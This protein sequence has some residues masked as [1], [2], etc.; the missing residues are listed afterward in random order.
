[1]SKAAILGMDVGG[2]S[3]RSAL[4]HIEDASLSPVPF[5]EHREPTARGVEAHGQQM[6]RIIILAAEQANPLI[7]I[8]VGSPGRFDAEGKIKPG[9]NP[10]V[11]M[12]VHEFDGVNLADLYRTNLPEAFRNIPLNVRNDADAMLAGMIHAIQQEK[13]SSL[14]ANEIEGRTLALFGLGTGLGHS[15]VKLDNTGGYQF[16]TDGH[17]SKLRLPIDQEDIAFVL[18]AAAYA[19][20]LTGAEELVMLDEHTIRAED[21]CRSRM[22]NAMARVEHGS[23]IDITKHEQHREAIRISGKY[24][25]RLMGMIHRRETEDIELANGWNEAEKAQAAETTLYL[26]GGGLGESPLGL[27]MIESAKTELTAQGIGSIRLE[28]LIVQNAASFAAALMASQDH[29]ME[30]A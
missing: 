26:F 7:A 24:L 10:N 11:G 30:E 5:W 18:E 20:S 14:S 2:Q 19:T 23:E 16:V 3:I 17:A 4:Y 21:V 13:L 1:M 6:A 12:A 15:I 28:Q 8:G 22:V 27:Q 25:G 29:V 9:S